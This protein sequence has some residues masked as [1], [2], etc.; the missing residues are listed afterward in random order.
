M[1]VEQYGEHAA[2]VVG[3]RGKAELAEDTGDVSLGGSECDDQTVRDAW[4]ERPC[5]VWTS[6][7]R[8]RGV[9]T[10]MGSSLRRLERSVE[11]MIGSM[12]EPPSATRRTA[13]MNSLT[14]LILSLSR[15]LAPSAESES[16]FIANPTSTYWDSTSTLTDGCRARISSA[17]CRP[18]SLWV[19]G[20]RMST[21]ATSG[22]QLAVF[23]SRYCHGSG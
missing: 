11:T 16:N 5:A 10:A 14:S 9:N 4:I 15:Y 23:C 8:S 3:C 21:I 1:Q 20:R 12:A 7:S 13:P 2:R 18:S 22:V 19:G 6:T 17:A